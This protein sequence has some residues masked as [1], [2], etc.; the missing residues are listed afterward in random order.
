LRVLIVEDEPLVRLELES[1]VAGAG[2]HVVGAATTGE[3]AIRVAEEQ[4]PDVVLMDIALVGDVNGI[5]AAKAIHERCGSRSLFVS[6]ISGHLRDS[7][8]GAR[9]FGFLL[10]PIAPE[11][12][13]A[14][15]KEIARQ[16]GKSG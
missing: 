11:R 14:A 3:D 16:L 9:P 1:I 12:L 5:D 4:R 2:H 6:A 8:D 15:L 10:K 7:A 13:V